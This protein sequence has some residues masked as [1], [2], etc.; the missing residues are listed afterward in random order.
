MKQLSATGNKPSC[1]LLYTSVKKSLRSKISLSEFDESYGIL[2]RQIERKVE[3]V[4]PRVY[5]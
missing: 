2:D 4:N 1:S 3:S 5:N